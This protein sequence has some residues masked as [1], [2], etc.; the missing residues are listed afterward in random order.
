[1]KFGSSKKIMTSPFETFFEDQTSNKVEYVIIQRLKVRKDLT[2][3]FFKT[4]E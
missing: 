2:A 1:M 4:I 3:K